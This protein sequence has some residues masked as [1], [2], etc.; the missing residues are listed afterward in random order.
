V[1]CDDV[2]LARYVDPP[3]TTVRL[4]AYELGF[5]AATVL[6]DLIAGERVEPRGELLDTELV[7]RQSCG[8]ARA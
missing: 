4:P 7:V 8:A 1:G 3:L 6:L 5:R 2:Q